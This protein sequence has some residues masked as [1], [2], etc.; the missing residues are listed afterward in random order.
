MCIIKTTLSFIIRQCSDR[1]SMPIKMLRLALNHLL[2]YILYIII[3]HGFNIFDLSPINTQNDK[4]WDCAWTN[5]FKYLTWGLQPITQCVVKCVESIQLQPRTNIHYS[6]HRRIYYST[7]IMHTLAYTAI[8]AMSTR[9]NYNVSEAIPFNTDSQMIGVD[10]RC[11]A[12]ITHVRGDM[13][14]EL[15][16]CHRSIK[17]FGGAKVW[18]V[19][20]GTIKWY[21][22]DDT[23][24]KHTLIIPNSYYV[25][26][27]K[28][29]LLSPQ[30]WA[31]A[32]TGVDKNGG[33]GTLTTATTCTLFS[34]NKSAFRTIPIDVKGNNVATFYM[35][36]GYQRFHD[37]CLTTN[38]E[39][40]ESDPLTQMEVDASLISDDEES[41]QFE[42]QHTD[43]DTDGESRTSQESEHTEKDPVP[44]SFNL[45]GPTTTDVE[46]IPNIIT[47]EEDR[48]TE[49]P[50]AELLRYHYDMG[51]ISFAKLQQ[52]A[53]QRVLPHH[54]SKC[55]IPVCSACQYAKAT[56]R[57]WR[58]K[59][60][61]RSNHL[62]P[63][64]KPGEVI[65]VDQLV[66]PVPGLIAQMTGFITKQRYK[67]AT[68]Y[69]DQ[70]S[71]FSF[72]YLQRTASA[73]E[74]LQSKQAMERYAQARNITINAY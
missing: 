35:A 32:R 26:Q 65:S 28:V 34:N 50:T 64:S 70:F 4:W 37:Y 36:T 43:M 2:L 60:A 31:Q 57:P 53:K 11:S 61:S 20:C 40:Y 3:L 19:W 48:I 68:V 9:Q 69:I 51:H 6:P 49:T 22:E 13:P 18:E 72:V 46:H 29:R 7:R 30:H 67:Y 42:N 1:I 17:G 45:D 14:G 25:P 63:P 44:R 54:L 10:N 16:P 33:A 74:T 71:G 27:A 24:V 41:D 52:M 58:A 8:N 47:D 56:R 73:Q 23:G 39:Q 5:F 21:I 62:I 66:S 12:C 59:I 15:V 38:I 55:A